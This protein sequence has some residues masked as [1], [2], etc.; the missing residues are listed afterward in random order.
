VRPGSAA[1]GAILLVAFAGCHERWLLGPF[2]GRRQAPE[3]LA[4]SSLDPRDVDIVEQRSHGSV[5]Y[6]VHLPGVAHSRALRLELRFR[7]PLA[8]ARVDAHGTG[9]RHALTLVNRRRVGGDTIAVPLAPLAFERVDVI[10]HHH[11]RAVPLV[12]EVRLGAAP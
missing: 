10:V 7:E 11:L 12:Q 3:A 9:P 8:G 6:R 4:W 2:E 1:L 5:R